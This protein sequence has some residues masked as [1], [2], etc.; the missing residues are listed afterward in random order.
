MYCDS[1][2]RTKETKCA[3]WNARYA[4]REAGTRLDERGYIQIHV[5]GKLY[6]AHRLAWLHTTGEWPKAEIDHKDRKPGNNRI[7]NLREASH[8]QNH[9]NR[10]RV[11]NSSGVRGVSWCKRDRNWLAQIKLGGKAYRL[12]QFATIAEARAVYVAAKQKHF[13]EFARLD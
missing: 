9:A 3:A 7:S 11:P 2:K 13:G 10:G 12:G 1:P 8:S 5:I 6:L 4:G